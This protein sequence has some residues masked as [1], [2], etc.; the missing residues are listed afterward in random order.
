MI[1]GYSVTLV[2][3][4]T[5]ISLQWEDVIRILAAKRKVVENL[6]SVCDRCV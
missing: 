5:A 2:T 1:Y 3:Q 4:T 6:T